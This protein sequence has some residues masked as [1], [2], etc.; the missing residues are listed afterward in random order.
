MTELRTSEALLATLA[1]A[2]RRGVTAEELRQQRIS[3]IVGS[4]KG[5]S[6]ITRLRVQEVLAQQERKSA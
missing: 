3:F 1:E 5:T 6:T 2:S 4:L